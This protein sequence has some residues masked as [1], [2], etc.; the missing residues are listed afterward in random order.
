L[1]AK[2]ETGQEPADIQ[3]LAA[4]IKENINDSMES[5]CKISIDWILELCHRIYNSQHFK[6]TFGDPQNSSH[7][8]KKAS[9]D[10]TTENIPISSNIYPQVNFIQNSIT[11]QI[12]AHR[13]EFTENN[14]Y[15]LS[16][17]SCA[18]D[19][20]GFYYACRRL[21]TTCI[22]ILSLFKERYNEFYKEVINRTATK[23][24]RKN[25]IYICLLG[26]VFGHFVNIILLCV[27]VFVHSNMDFARF[28][29]FVNHMNEITC[30]IEAKICNRRWKQAEEIL[31]SCI[32]PSRLEKSTTL[33]NRD[34]EKFW[35]NVNSFFSDFLT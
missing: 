10:P 1:S 20:C 27:E 3:I 14:Y 18:I 13:K 34:L 21:V 5:S 31:W 9:S 16:K 33:S 25:F 15:P 26:P 29:S 2:K 11:E 22:T 17:R 19:D 6:Q 4:A 28:F 12:I 7:Q 35:L 30:S 23:R 8:I 24:N 32:T